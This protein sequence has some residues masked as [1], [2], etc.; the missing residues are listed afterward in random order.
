MSFSDFTP[1][2]PSE[3][4]TEAQKT[5]QSANEVWNSEPDE[6]DW[7]PRFTALIQIADVWAKLAAIPPR[8]VGM[9]YEE[10]EDL[11]P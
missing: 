4:Y 9:N 3:A 8:N 1:L 7:L 6:R 5:L 11:R 10:E 2:S